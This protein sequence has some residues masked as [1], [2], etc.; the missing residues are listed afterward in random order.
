MR[1]KPRSKEKIIR[2][3]RW[4]AKIKEFEDALFVRIVEYPGCTA[5][6]KKEEFHY[7]QDTMRAALVRYLIETGNTGLEEFDAKVKRLRE[8]E[9]AAER[10]KPQ[11]N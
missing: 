1:M 4:H 6:F 2:V 7:I 11:P 3:G 8:K 5:L 10:E 9:K